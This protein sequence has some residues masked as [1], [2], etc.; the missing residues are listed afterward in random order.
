MKFTSIILAVVVAANQFSSTFATST[1]PNPVTDIVST[2]D[3]VPI[4]IEVLLNDKDKDNVLFDP[5]AGYDVGKI[6]SASVVVSSSPST[7]F[8]T[9][10]NNDGSILFAPTLG[11][12]G[13][14]SFNYKVS[15]Y[16]GC[17]RRLSSHVSGDTLV[18][19]TVKPAIVAPVVEIKEEISNDAAGNQPKQ[20]LGA[21]VIDILP[22]TSKDLYDGLLSQVDDPK[23]FLSNTSP[24]NQQLISE[25]NTKSFL[26][27][28][29]WSKPC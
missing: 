7:D 17:R 1:A 21:Q 23:T 11:K 12:T 9:T 22:G 20:V 13:T 16:Q 27:G 5:N 15:A 28:M 4:T 19:V 26:C 2:S 18:T 8:A 6:N 29:P 3:G 25:E 14:F 10:V 24:G